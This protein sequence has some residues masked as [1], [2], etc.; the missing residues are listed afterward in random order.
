[1]SLYPKGETIENLFN[2][3]PQTPPSFEKNEAKLDAFLKIL[4]SKNETN[5][6]LFK[7]LTT[8]PVG[9]FDDELN[10]GDEIS[11]SKLNSI[12]EE[13]YPVCFARKSVSN[14]QKLTFSKLSQCLTS[15]LSVFYN[16]SIL[17]DPSKNFKIFRETIYQAKSRSWFLERRIR[18]SAS[19]AHKILK[20][21][22]LQTRLKYFFDDPPISKAMRYG[23]QM[24]ENAREKFQIVTQKTV[25]RS[26]LIVK[27]GQSWLCGSPD[28]LLSNENSCLE[29]KCP[30]SCENTDLNVEYIKENKLKKN[31]PYYT[32][33]QLQMY[34]SNSKECYLFLYSSKDF[35]VI[36]VERDDDYL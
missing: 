8:E 5:G 32:Q 18:I 29:I 16:S 11:D 7:T 24:E 21:R 22:K 14:G 17:T 25:Q 15:E 4:S 2:L 36:T 3:K 23:S 31:H 12:F 35:L 9:D 26:G 34:I 28:G 10:V 33:V 6:M 1:M 27:T 13:I 19:K 30:F 20:A